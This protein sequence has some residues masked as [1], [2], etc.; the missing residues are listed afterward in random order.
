ME[1]AAEK[2][3]QIGATLPESFQLTFL[4][5]WEAVSEKSL[6]TYEASR[7]PHWSPSSRVSEIHKANDESSVL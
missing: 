1:E 5:P 7:F 4:T 2:Q 6:L 3:K